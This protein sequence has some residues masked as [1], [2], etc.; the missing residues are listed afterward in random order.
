MPSAGVMG[1]ESVFA[2]N[3]V[4]TPDYNLLP[5]DRPI[6]QYNDVIKSHK[7][8]WDQI[9]TGGLSHHP[10]VTVGCDVSPRWPGAILVLS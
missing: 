2:Y 10:V 1:F 9:E 3:I 4:R 7:Y 6:V 5:D 8:C